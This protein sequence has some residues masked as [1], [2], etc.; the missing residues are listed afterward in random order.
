[1]EYHES[2]GVIPLKKVKGHW[3]VLLIK[4]HS[5]GHWSFP[6]GHAEKGEGPKEVAIRELFEETGLEVVSFLSEETLSESYMFF[7]KGQRISKKVHYFLCEVEG[8]LTLQEGEVAESKWV[9]FKQVEGY[10]T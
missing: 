7:L 5:G 8:E 9:S 4:L 2:F 6:K 1:M 3:K 10:V